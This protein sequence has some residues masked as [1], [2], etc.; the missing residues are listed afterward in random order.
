MTLAYLPLLLR[1]EYSVYVTV[2][3][4]FPEACVDSKTFL[5]LLHYP[6]DPRA[7][8]QGP[9]SRSWVGVGEHK[10]VSGLAGV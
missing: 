4:S 3:G 9:E 10:A 1:P 6:A 8:D 7:A 2:V 5:L